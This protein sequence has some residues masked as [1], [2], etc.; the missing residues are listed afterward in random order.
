MYYTSNAVDSNKYSVLKLFTP[1]EGSE[2]L[3][4]VIMKITI[5]WDAMQSY[6]LQTLTLVW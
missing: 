6:S 2:I 1:T 3:M 4:A 5:S